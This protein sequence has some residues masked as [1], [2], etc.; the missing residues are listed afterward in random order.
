MAAT[1]LTRVIGCVMPASRSQW[2]L[3]RVA[4]WLPR[5]IIGLSNRYS[6]KRTNR[7]DHRLCKPVVERPSTPVAKAPIANI[8]A[9]DRCS[10][11]IGAAS[12]WSPVRDRRT[13]DSC[14]FGQAG[15]FRGVATSGKSGLRPFG[16][17]AL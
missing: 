10:A 8:G 11:I 4:H 2:M 14:A 6:I 9:H 12:R 17:I 5:A 3:R 1:V 15:L 16:R 7:A 13:A